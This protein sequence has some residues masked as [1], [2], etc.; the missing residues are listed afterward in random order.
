MVYFG[1]GSK[2][3]N[4]PKGIDMI[5]EA[6]EVVRKTPYDE[7]SYGCDARFVKINDE[8][9]MKFY[10]SSR[11]RDE[12]YDLQKEFAGYGLAPEVG[13]V[14]EFELNGDEK[15]AMI[16][17]ICPFLACDHQGGN[18]DDN[19]EYTYFK[20]ELYD[21]G[22]EFGDCHDGNWGWMDAPQ[23]QHIVCIDFF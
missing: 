8:W 18:L 9:G 6:I 7:M 23:G 16:T 14:F 13:D 11:A 17:E 3:H 12:A 20:D 2:G 21:H 10:T 19:D 4:L 15:F 1:H 22:F 5:A